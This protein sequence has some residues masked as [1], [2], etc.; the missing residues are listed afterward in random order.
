MGKL[1]A[2]IAKSTNL[3]AA[4]LI[5]KLNPIIRGWAQYFNLSQS[6]YVRNRM[7]A[8]LIRLTF[9]WARRKHPRWGKTKIAQ[10]YFIKNRKLTEST[11]G[12]MDYTTGNDNKWVFTGWVDPSIYTESKGGKFIELV[13]PTKLV[14]TL[15]AYRYRIPERLELVHAYHE[16]YEELIDFNYALI[17]QAMKDNTS[18]KAKL[19]IKQKGRCGICGSSL[20]DDNGTLD[21]MD[22]Y[23]IHHIQPRSF[24]FNNVKGGQNQMLVHSEHA[25]K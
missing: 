5:A 8:E 24:V 1:K 7:N 25:I 19:F 12:E 11:L 16:K 21:Y 13:N 2:I 4:T 14:S 22:S 23:R 10:R 3:T 9:A 15:S 20:L 17:K 18:F 6:Y